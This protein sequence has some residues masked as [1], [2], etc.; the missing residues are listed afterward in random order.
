MEHTYINRFI[1]FGR[2]PERYS[3]VLNELVGIQGW[4]V[5]GK[6][7][8]LPTVNF[9]VIISS[10]AVIIFLLHNKLCNML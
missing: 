7:D 9:R 1:Q 10:R 5:Y 2:D 4:I 3:D 8:L 6:H